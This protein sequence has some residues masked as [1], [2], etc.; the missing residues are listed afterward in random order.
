MAKPKV[1]DWLQDEKLI[2]LE[3][4]ARDG[5]TDEQ[6]A[7]NMGISARTL[8]RWKDK[9]CQIC[10]AL[11][12]GKEA[13]DRQVEN[14]LFKRAIG[15]KYE[16]VRE[17]SK[18]GIVTK[19]TVTTKHIPGDTTAQIFWLKNRKPDYWGGGN[20]FSEE[21]ADV[22]IYLPDNGRSNKSNE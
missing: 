4:W 15:Y 8:Y 6:I 2:I 19:R 3:G 14:A 1:D 16:E 13:A 5:L 17:E 21:G 18:G 11:K 22:Q 10:Q 12:K 9:Y 20:E 7:E